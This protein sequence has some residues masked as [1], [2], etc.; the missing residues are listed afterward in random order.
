MKVMDNE[1]RDFYDLMSALVFLSVFGLLMIGS[2]Y[3]R[4]KEQF[5]QSNKIQKSAVIKHVKCNQK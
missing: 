1:N 3:L 4:D 5:I 2:C